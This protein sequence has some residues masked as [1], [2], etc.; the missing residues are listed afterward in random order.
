VSTP[1][2]HHQPDR[3][4][5]LVDLVDEQ[6][7]SVGSCSVAQAHTAPGL[8]HRAFSVL[9]FDKDNR[10]L[11]Q[12]RAAVKTRFPS[13]WSNT[14][15]GHPAPGQTLQAAAAARLIAEMGLRAPLTPAG[16]Y[17]Y[18]AEDAATARVEHEWDHVLIGVLAGPVP[19]PDPAEV[20]DWA[21]AHPAELAA[22]I[23]ADPDRYSPWLGGVLDLAV[24]HLEPQ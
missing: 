19:H 4:A 22:S 5:L 6:G 13:R 8:L 24:G 14:C 10:V 11:L 7:R 18:R 17:R 20:A 9:L 1:E 12:Q 16:V 3:E 21:W 23:S 2:N 15:C